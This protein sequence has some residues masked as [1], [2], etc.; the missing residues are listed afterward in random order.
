MH[1]KKSLAHPKL[2][3]LVH[4]WLVD[5]I[6]PD[7]LLKPFTKL[8]ITLIWLV[9]F[10][11]NQELLNSEFGDFRILSRLLVS[12]N[13]T[14]SHQSNYDAQTADETKHS[15]FRASYIHHSSTSASGKIVR[16]SKIEIIGR[17]RINRNSN[18]KKKPIVPMNIAQSHC[19]GL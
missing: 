7:T 16:I 19:V 14:D 13:K 4:P 6:A 15:P 11:V 8:L 5:T 2:S 18:A 12:A 3:H 1:F 10:H 9:A 17:K